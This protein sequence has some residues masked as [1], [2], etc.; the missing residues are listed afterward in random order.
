MLEEIYVKRQRCVNN[1]I[2]HG[3]ML[4][5]LQYQLGLLGF[6]LMDTRFVS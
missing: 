4:T 1:A 3:L 6:V 5:R 2:V